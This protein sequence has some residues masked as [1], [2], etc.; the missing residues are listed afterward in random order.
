M[1]VRYAIVGS[2]ANALRS[3]TSNLREVRRDVDDFLSALYEEEGW[4]PLFPPGRGWR[5]N[6]PDAIHIFGVEGS[7]AATAALHRAGFR[8]VTTHDHPAGATCR[9]RAI[10]AGAASEQ[11]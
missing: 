9:C 5:F 11:G 8:S 10:I 6:E 1:D 3:A 7:P 4:R 2:L